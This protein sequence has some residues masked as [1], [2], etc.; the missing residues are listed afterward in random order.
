MLIK[1]DD[2]SKVIGSPIANTQRYWP[3]IITE[4]SARGANKLAFQ[5]AII[6]TIGVESGNFVPI[7]ERGSEKYFRT[8]Y[9]IEGSRPKV[10]LELGN[11][12]PG[13]G[14][15]FHGRGFIQIT[16]R[17]NYTAYGKALHLDLVGNPDLANDASAAVLILVKYCLDHGIDVWADRAFRTDDDQ[18]YPEEMCLIKIRKLVN[19]GTRHYD[20]FRKIWMA[21]KAIVRERVR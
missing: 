8:M 6:S 4:L 9:D 2:I 5:M 1:P 10:A 20:K 12:E 17:H 16:G 18:T 13:D 11:T 19:G 14:V 21:L 7:S 15:R 3:E